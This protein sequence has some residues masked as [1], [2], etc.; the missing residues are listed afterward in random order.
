MNLG[1]VEI[2][3]YCEKCGRRLIHTSV[4]SG[5]ILRIKDTCTNPRCKNEVSGKLFI[6][7]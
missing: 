4:V 7:A 1:E 2:P 5:Q 3:R 6:R